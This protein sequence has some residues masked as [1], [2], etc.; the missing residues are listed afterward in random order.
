MKAL[1]TIS[2]ILCTV[3]MLFE[4]ASAAVLKNETVNSVMS[5]TESGEAFNETVTNNSSLSS[6]I[7]E[8]TV[9]P[10]GVVRQIF[11]DSLSACK[12][13]WGWS[14]KMQTGTD[15]KVGEKSMEIIGSKDGYR[16]FYL[17]FDTPLKINKQLRDSGAVE[18]WVK[19]DIQ[20]KSLHLVLLNED[21]GQLVTNSTPLAS[22]VSLADVS[23]DWVKVV[24]PLSKYAL[25][26]SYYSSKGDAVYQPFDFEN[27]VG[28]G[29]GYSLPQFEGESTLSID[30]LC[31]TNG[32]VESNMLGVELLERE[33]Y[34]KLNRQ[35]T[36]IDLRGIMN[37][38]YADEIEGDGVGGWTDQG[39]SNDMS[40]FDM[41]GKNYIENI[42]FDIVDPVANN[43][44]SC[45][46][47]RGQTFTHFP[48]QVEVDINNTFKSIYF[49]HCAA[50]A[51][52]GARAS[53]YIFEY[54]DGTREEIPVI[55]GEHT[56]NWWGAADKS[57]MRT[58][59]MGSNASSASVSIYLFA[60]A[61]PQPDKVV[62]KLIMKSVEGGAVPVIVAITTSADKAYLPQLEYLG[63]PDTSD[64]FAYEQPD[65]ARRRGTILD[66]SAYL[67][68][69][70]GKHGFIKLDGDRIVFEDGESI[71]FFGV[72]VVA[73]ANFLTHE[74]TD[75]LVNA[76]VCSGVNVVRMHHLDANFYSPNIFGKDKASNE[77]D[78]E[79][80][81]R[82]CYF[83]AKLKQNGI[84]FMPGLLCAREAR[85][86]H[87]IIDANNVDVGYKIE[88]VFDPVMRQQQKKYAKD[89]FTWVNPYTGTCIAED[90]AAVMF[91]INNECNI[92]GYGSS[93]PY[94]I[95]SKY[96]LD[97]FYGLFNDWLVEK[98]GTHSALSSAWTEEGKVS[99]L[100]NENLDKRTITLPDT[101]LA[102]GLS[103]Q[104][105][106]DSYAFLYHLGYDHH[107]DMINYL[108]NEL[109]VKNPIC[110]VNNIIMHDAADLHENANYDHLDRHIYWAHPNGYGIVPGT[111]VTQQKSEISGVSSNTYGYMSTQ[112][113]YGK[114]LMVSEYQTVDINQYIAETSLLAST[115]FSYQGWNGTQF[116]F[117]Q[118]NLPYTGK[119]TDCFGIMEN[120]LRYA[121]LQAACRSSLRDDV[122][123]GKR[124]Y[125][126][127]YNY[128]DVLD[129]A[130][131]ATRL[132]G[133]TY[134]V[135]KAS[136]NIPDITGLHPESNEEMLD[137]AQ[138]PVRVSDTEE[139]IWDEKN[140]IFRLNTKKTQAVSGDLCGKNI[141]LDDVD[142]CIENDI[143]TVI[144]QSVDDLPISEAKTLLLTVGA[145]TR[146]TDMKLS[147][148]G[149]TIEMSGKPPILVEPVT[150]R[151]VLKSSDKFRVHTINTSG[152]REKEIKTE[153]T[154]EGY[155]A[156]ELTKDDKA[157]HYEIERVLVG[158]KIELPELRDLNMEP[159][160][161]DIIRE[162]YEKKY[163]SPLTSTLFVPD[164][165]ISIG[166][167]VAGIVRA[168]KLED[169]GAEQFKDVTEYNDNKKE[170]ITARSANILLG[171]G[172]NAMPYRMITHDTASA[173]LKR[174]G[175]GED[176]TENIFGEE[177]LS[178]QQ[179]SEIFMLIEK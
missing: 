19:T 162:A 11:D 167:F 81:D 47:L 28:L 103:Q 76:L 93:S 40:G 74:E 20:Y 75:I 21:N 50:W 30:D 125:Y 144:M 127:D 139:I 128:E 2:C 35:F 98:Y 49:M 6:Q 111:S 105:L 117:L 120:P 153:K 89:L 66:A 85:E 17:Q 44:K 33:E 39:P 159:E 133:G 31:I 24:V 97:M 23:K 63:N 14:Y 140:I 13:K 41:R 4:T 151:I 37:M 160:K 169:T 61:N 70:A 124:G 77:L 15:A 137:D 119:L 22:I 79:Q 107:T 132:P 82:F 146:N 177:Y 175:V 108:K 57:L 101:Y 118:G 51:S 58:A 116:E 149:R 92:T 143:A 59:W 16:A 60:C 88:G 36:T 168:L 145:R 90:P 32:N 172:E 136:V 52:A 113:V 26:G 7:T 156:F 65:Y 121:M 106:E 67:D 73:N 18:L 154:Q 86:E 173:L 147:P 29:F 53:T 80:M 87:G 83:W 158:E 142:M 72:N 112:K 114:P 5:N 129:P 165:N 8:D 122:S 12:E 99:F 3:A 179:A 176:I 163:I 115:I 157:L 148:D 96:Y 78:P 34:N 25:E 55:I 161:A 171:D 150:G 91:E 102:L 123:E 48:E 166:E 95:T 138:K 9:Y 84:Y 43:G 42:P 104:R 27:V 68:A 100:Q 1:K 62:K 94:K 141:G 155:T 152:K 178:R 164:G 126:T 71:R 174:A 54:E 130:Q 170:L 69:P 135:G 109:G 45:I 46:T 10:E 64:W 131:Q 56:A 38:G 134:L 110:G